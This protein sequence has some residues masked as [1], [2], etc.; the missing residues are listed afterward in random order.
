MIPNI[1]DTCIFVTAAKGICDAVH[2]MQ[3]ISAVQVD[4]T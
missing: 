3:F 1:T 2:L 4:E